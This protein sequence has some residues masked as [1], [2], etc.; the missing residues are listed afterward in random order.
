M[1]L[2]SLVF[3]I[4]YTLSNRSRQFNFVFGIDCTY[5]Q[6]SCCFIWVSSKIVPGLIVIDSSISFFGVD[7]TCI[8]CQV[9]VISS[10]CQRLHPILQVLTV[11]Y[12]FLRRL[13][14]YNRSCCC[15]VWFSS[16]TTFGLISHN[17]SVSFSSQ[18]MYDRSCCCHVFLSLE[19]SHSLIGHNSSLLFSVQTAFLRSVLSFFYLVFSSQTTSSLIGHNSSILFSLQIVHV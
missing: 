7:C 10:F 13:H 16:Q 12:H 5:N 17:S 19:T 8:I 4:D 3:I 2:S 15:L 14:L 11:Q 18:H 1:S 9:V 6:S